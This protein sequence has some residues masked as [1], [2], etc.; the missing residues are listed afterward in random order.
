MESASVGA[1]VAIIVLVLSLLGLGYGF[2]SADLL[3]GG[4]PTGSI[5]VVDQV[6]D[7]GPAYTITIN[8]AEGTQ[9]YDAE[10]S[11]L[12]GQIFLL[13]SGDGAQIVIDTTATLSAGAELRGDRFREIVPD[14]DTPGPIYLID[15]GDFLMASLPASNIILV[16]SQ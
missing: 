10:A 8:S 13:H 6:R 7:D 15:Y 9:I 1:Q 3:E 16:V 14:G 2:D 11:D 5:D 12:A 4:V